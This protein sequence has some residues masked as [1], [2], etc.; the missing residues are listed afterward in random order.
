MKKFTLMAL[1][2]VLLFGFSAINA[3][4]VAHVNSQE[5][6]EGMPAFKEAQTKIQSE[7]DRHKAEIERQQK[8]I[9]DIY[10][11]AQKQI[12][13]VKGKSEAEQRK[14]M[15]SLAPVEQDLQK[16]QQALNEYQQKAVQSISKMQAELLEPIYKKVQN[17]IEIVGGKENIGYIF[18]LAVMAPS[19]SL[20][21]YGGGKDVSALVKKQL[22]L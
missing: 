15:Q 6:L 14:V 1:F 7:N 22:G 9:Q 13:A 2:S 11:K 12:E 19:G 21:Y 16:K 8:E 18:D 5:I 17:A 3:Q 4:S 20:V 10:A